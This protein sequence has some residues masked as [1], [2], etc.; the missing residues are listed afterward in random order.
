MGLDGLSVTSVVDRMFERSW[1]PRVD[2]LF[3]HGLGGRDSAALGT[4]YNRYDLFYASGVEWYEARATATWFLPD[5]VYP[6]TDN[7]MGA[8]RAL[9]VQ[10]Q[11]VAYAMQDAYRERALRLQ[12]LA[13]ETLDDAQAMVVRAR[14]EALDAMLAAWSGG[15]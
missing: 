5:I 13:G 1:M 6:A 15:D 10:R 12:Q 14:V 9:Y 11:R 7:P 2:V 8:R 3:T 4:I